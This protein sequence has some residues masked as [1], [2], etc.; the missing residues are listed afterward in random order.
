MGQIKGKVARIIDE[1]TVIISVG[2]QHGVTSGMRFVIYEEG[3]EVL[4]PDT[5][6]SLGAWEVVKGEVVA[7]HVQERITIAQ[8]PPKEA[9]PLDGPVSALMAEVSKG[10]A[11]EMGRL[12][13]SR[14]DLSGRPQ[15]GP[16]AIGDHVRSIG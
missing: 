9:R 1:S 12:N 11:A 4:D 15:V 13:V 5:G 2:Q 7:K 10:R 6:E 14:S 3:E 8:A 16:V